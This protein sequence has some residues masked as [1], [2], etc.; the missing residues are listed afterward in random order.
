ML[1]KQKHASVQVT[2][3]Q[4]LFAVAVWRQYLSEYIW[5]ST[6]HEFWTIG[7]Y[8]SVHLSTSE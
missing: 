8:F 7:A 6:E 4:G 1:R 3:E 2:T 5:V